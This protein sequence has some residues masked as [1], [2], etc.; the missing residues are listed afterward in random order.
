[1]AKKIEEKYTEL[2]EIQH[3][4]LRPS[5]WVGSTKSEEKDMFIYN[6][7][8]GK[9]E[10]KIINYIPAM[11][12]VVDEVISNSCDEFRRKDNMGLTELHVWMYPDTGEIVIRD[13]GGIPIVKHKD[14]GVYVPEFIFGR[15][16][17]SS[18]YDDTENRNVIGTNG[19]GSALCNVFSTYF[20]IDSADGKNEFHRSWSNNMET[21]NND[22]SVKKCGKRTHYTETR[23]KLDYPRF[24]VDN[25]DKDF[26]NIIHKR[27]IDA[28]AAN[29]GL[30]VYFTVDR[31]EDCKSFDWKFKKLDEYI[32]LYSNILNIPDKI[33]FENDLCTAWIFPDSSVDI[34]FVNGAE[35]SKGT[36]MRALRNEINQ[37]IVDYLVKKDKLK[38]LTTR[39]VDSKYS[40]FINI[41]VS[42]PTYDSQNKET[43]TTPI[44][45][46]SKDNKLKWEVS[47]KFLNK[48]LKSEI[49]SLVRDWYKQKSA[50]EDEKALRK[51]NRETNKGLKRPDKY[52]TCSSKKKSERQLFIFEGDS[53]RS[54][55]RSGRIPE[56]Q[57]GLTMR[58]VPPNVYGMTPVQI[59][60]N[61]VYNDIVTVLGLKW[62]KEFNIDDLNFGK[63]VISTDADYDGDKIASLL[64]LFFNN[65]PELFD[66]NIVCRN[67]SPIIISRKG[68]DCQKFYTMNEFKEAEKKLK[69]YS[70]KYVKGL[71]GLSNSESKEMYQ[72]PKFLYFKKDEAADSMLRKWFNKSDSN[73]RKDM[74]KY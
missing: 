15:L 65:W 29:P 55:F 32:D 66:H 59:M 26:I 36:H 52:I 8:T 45:K 38:D 57:A 54:G 41:N 44:D 14:A 67:I 69:G 21:L 73:V 42:N 28:A 62:G 56:I 19:V 5:M 70:H 33:L 1:M 68:K 50:A 9:F 24:G 7:K 39:G 27:C 20:S 47:D 48:I 51:L 30:M 13:N 40:I 34:G 31:G 49:I 17:T 58:G 35:C 23:F 64:L 16:R 10:M 25:F 74:L 11:L 6:V 4:L 37:A 46:F 53:A 43:L 3:I 60:K 2:S 71:G 72:N 12:K 61:E 18:N 22:L 63:I